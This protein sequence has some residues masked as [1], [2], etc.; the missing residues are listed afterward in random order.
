MK[1]ST[2][3]F[4]V[5]AM[6]F[7]V[8]TGFMVNRLVQ[9]EGASPTVAG[10]SKAGVAPAGEEPPGLEAA[11]VMLWDTA[12]EEI[13]WQQNAF[14]RRPVASLTKLMTAMVA[15]DAG[16]PWEQAA[17][18]NPDEYGLGGNLLLLPG[19]SVTMRDLFTASLLGSANNA[20]HAYVRALKISEEEFVRRM[21]R[22]AIELGLEQTYF[23][24]VT[25]LKPS[26]VSTAYEVARMAQVA[27]QLYPDIARATAQA[28]YAFT[29]QGSEREHIIK[30]TNRLV[31]DHLLAVTGSKTGYLD[32]AKYCL[33]VQGAETTSRLIAVVLGSPSQAVNEQ[34]VYKLL[35][36]TR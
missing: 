14:E 10:A 24:D 18:I 5:L 25:G 29:V 9:H 33:V 36:A 1:K 6:V 30:N 7:T 17:T 2:L 21:N 16:M 8:L 19:E 3:F 20:T 32:D 23:T 11:S 35:Q 22:K 28:E 15:I 13:V 4:L 26:T 31:T 27:F 34:E 12:K